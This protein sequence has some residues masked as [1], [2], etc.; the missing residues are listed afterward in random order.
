MIEGELRSR[1]FTIG[2]ADALIAATAMARG[3]GVA[4]LNGK[5]FRRVP[6]LNV[7]EM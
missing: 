2:F 3:D 7:L 5:H 4:T 6:Q 1:G